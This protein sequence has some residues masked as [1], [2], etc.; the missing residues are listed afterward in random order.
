MKNRVFTWRDFDQVEISLAGSYQ[1]LNAALALQAVTTLHELGYPVSRENIYEGLQKDPLERTFY[2]DLQR[3][4]SDHG[5][6][7]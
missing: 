1:I 6:S 2:S 5:R 3:T 4:G 7:P